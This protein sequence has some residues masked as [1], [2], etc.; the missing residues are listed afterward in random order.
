M[1]QLIPQAMQSFRQCVLDAD[2]K[3]VRWPE[4]ELPMGFQVRDEIPI[5]LT[6]RE[7]AGPSDSNRLRGF[8]AE[9]MILPYIRCHSILGSVFLFDCLASI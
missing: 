8:G 4:L 7:A 9:S 6:R 5:R 2:A 3:M 1:N